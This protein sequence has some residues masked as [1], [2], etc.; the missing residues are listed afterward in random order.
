M[1]PT[2]GDSK[3]LEV[4]PPGP[5]PDTLQRGQ[6]TR[7]NTYVPEDLSIQLRNVGARIRKSVTEGY[8]TRK[9][10]G[11][12]IAPKVSDPRSQLGHG[13]LRPSIF[14]SSGESM[15]RVYTTPHPHSRP[16]GGL[17]RF[18]DFGEPPARYIPP[19]AGG[20]R[21]RATSLGDQRTATHA[22]A[23]PSGD[24]S[25]SKHATT[26]GEADSD[27][28]SDSELDIAK[29]PSDKDTLGELFEFGEE[30]RS[31]AAGSSMFGSRPTG[32]PAPQGTRTFQQTQSL[33]AG[34]LAFGVGGARATQLESLGEDET[35]RQ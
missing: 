35:W 29:S 8:A 3:Q 21:V 18:A 32:V 10:D 12:P 26:T 22:G 27:S 24:G 1:E 2:D 34:S 23:A 31:S 30:E 4:N 16:T 13:A 28:D 5:T 19:T 14:Q 6:F 9:W 33:P 7:V 15:R 11:E 25:S 17:Q 20:M